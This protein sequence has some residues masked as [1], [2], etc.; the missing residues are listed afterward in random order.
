MISC[1]NHD[2]V[3]IACMYKMPLKLVLKS[4]LVIHCTALDTMRNELGE[5]CMKVRIDNDDGF[6]VL[7][8][9]YT[10]EATTKNRHFTLIKLC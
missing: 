9:I 3:E 4:D 10:M 2:Y 1:D 8:S 6:I 5:E 7:D